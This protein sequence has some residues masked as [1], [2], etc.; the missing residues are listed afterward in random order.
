MNPFFP[1]LFFFFCFFLQFYVHD[2]KDPEWL[3]QH[4]ISR[5]EFDLMRRMSTWA[6]C[7]FRAHSKN[8]DQ[9]DSY[10]HDHQQTTSST[11]QHNT[12]HSAAPSIQSLSNVE[13]EQIGFLIKRFLDEGRAQYLLKHA[14]FGRASVEQYTSRNITREN[15]LLLA[16]S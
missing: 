14:S 16:S 15:A 13:R 6:T 5:Y 1:F 12:M 11:T 9:D 10:S 3:S 2:C 4:D 7:A 8:K